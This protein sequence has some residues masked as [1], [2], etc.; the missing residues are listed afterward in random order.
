VEPAR[1]DDPMIWLAEHGLRC[2]R[3]RA[4]LSPSACDTHQRWDPEACHKCRRSRSMRARAGWAGVR[5][6]LTPVLEPEFA[7]HE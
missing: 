4:T 6:K 7:S 2:E 5:S 1:I 3:Y